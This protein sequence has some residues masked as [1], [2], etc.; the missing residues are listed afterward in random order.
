M[1][2]TYAIDGGLE[3]KQRLDVL[4]RVCAPG[5]A[6]LLD[7]V[8][9]HPG[10]RCLDVGCGG[11]HVS[12]ELARRAGVLGSVVAIDMDATVLELAREDAETESLANIEFRCADARDLDEAKYDLVYARF[13]LSHVH[14]PASVLGRICAALKPDGRVVVEDIDFSGYFCHPRCEAHDRWVELYRETVRRRGGNADLGLT[15]P[16][17]I[18]QAGCDP[19]E[20]TVSQAC[21]VIGEAK[22]I[23]P[24]TLER[25]ANA[26]VAEDVATA[27]EVA[28]T[29]AELY[30]YAADPTTLMGMPRV[31]Q[32]W[33]TR[34]S[35]RGLPSARAAPASG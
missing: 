17:L 32:A 26:V 6:A 30:G 8:G 25:I 10:A 3:G 29:C 21:G 35:R 5:T 20:V 22:L 27:D 23:P 18:Q 14:D 33:G 7:R 9:I 12:R 11:G 19:T 31:I 16:S 28:A 4:A 2:A 24:L 1:S 34:S 15:L 13:L